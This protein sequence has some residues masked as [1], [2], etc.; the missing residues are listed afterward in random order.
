ME[1][2][3]LVVLVKRV[4]V[5]AFCKKRVSCISKKST[6]LAVLVKRGEVVS[7]VRK[8]RVEEVSRDSKKKRIPW[9]C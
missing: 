2:R 9:W 1:E 3:V 4:G 6:G 5:S 8:K 7:G